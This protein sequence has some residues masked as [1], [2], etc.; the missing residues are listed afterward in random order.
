M[1]VTLKKKAEAFV[2]GVARC[3][4]NPGNTYGLGA[5]IRVL[6]LVGGRDGNTVTSTRKAIAAERAWTRAVAA[7][8][9]A[10]K[11]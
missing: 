7:Y 6:G 4:G 1:R 5:F 10:Q 8:H 9:A 2:E 11:E 3:G